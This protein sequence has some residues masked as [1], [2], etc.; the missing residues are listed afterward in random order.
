MGSDGAPDGRP[1]PGGRAAAG[2]GAAPG[3]RAAR[4]RRRGPRSDAARNAARLLDAA[5]ELVEESGPEVA[6]DEVARLAG[7]G[8]ATLYRH[9]PTR[10]DLLV[11]V[12]AEEVTALCDRGSALLGEPSPLDGLFA[13]LDAFAV[14]I[15]TKRALALAATRQPSAE[16]TELFDRWHSSI[17]SITGELL[18]RAQRA[19]TVTGDVTAADVLA[20]TSGAAHAA[21]S[22]EHARKLVAHLRD[23]LGRGARSSALDAPDPSRN[24]EAPG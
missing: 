18:A 9:F 16:R 15:S 19:G 13:W 4:G 8:N 21:T 3:A 10:G 7:V 2:G 1:A 22:T 17:R 6:L 20:L 23:G 14:H 24:R 5:R 12:Y 11:A